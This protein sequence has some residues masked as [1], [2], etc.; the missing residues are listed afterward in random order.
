[1]NNKKCY[2]PIHPPLVDR[3]NTQAICFRAMDTSSHLRTLSELT[4]EMRNLEVQT[5][6]I[7]FE[8]LL[9]HLTAGKPFDEFCR[10]YHT[11]LHTGRF[12]SWVFSKTPRRDAYYVAKA[13]GAESIE[14][15]LVRIS[16]GI[17]VDG[18]PSVEDVA[19]STLRITTRKW[20]LQVSNR[21]RYGD[22]KHIEQ[23][24]TTRFDPATLTTEQLE[25]KIL[26]ALGMDDS[27]YSLIGDYSQ[28]AQDAQTVD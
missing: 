17:S 27:G 28:D 9:E 12:R 7:A 4:P 26:E 18:S 25:H 24:T 1:L 6:T 11:P 2:S 20:L 8:S 16:D 15:E 5:F 22:V 23:T 19:R 13:I 10:T 14:D 3:C 21:K